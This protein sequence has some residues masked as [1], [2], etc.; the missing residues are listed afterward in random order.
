L[1]S[2]DPQK[3]AITARI[4]AAARWG[5]NS[6]ELESAHRDLAAERLAEYVAK[7]VATAPPLT[8]TQRERI[9]ALLAP[10]GGVTNE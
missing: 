3:R 6:P 8:P 4:A 2:P 5:N 9:A 1:P 10:V 7:V